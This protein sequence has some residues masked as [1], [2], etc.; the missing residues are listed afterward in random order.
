MVLEHIRRTATTIK[1]ESILKALCIRCLKIR[2]ATQ[3]ANVPNDTRIV[4]A[5]TKSL[6]FPNFFSEKLFPKNRST[7]MVI[8]IVATVMKIIV[9]DMTTEDIPT[10]AAVVNFDITSQKT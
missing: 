3:H 7:P 9:I 2:M 5:L 1:L 10:V 6:A 8:P 4:E